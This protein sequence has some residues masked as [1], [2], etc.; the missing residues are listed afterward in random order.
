MVKSLLFAPRPAAL[1][2]RQRLGKINWG[3]VMVLA[4][5]AAIGV[6]M[7]YSVAGGV[8]EPWA[9]RHALRFLGG[10]M[11]LT[12][13]AVVDLRWWMALA[14]PAYVLSLL[15][16]VFVEVAGASGMG[17]QRWLDLGAFRIQPSELMKVALI[18]A[19]ARYFHSLPPESYRK[20]LPLLVPVL[21][22]AIPAAL[23]VRQPDLGTAA[24]LVMGGLGIIFLAGAR[25]WIFWSG[26]AASLAAIPFVWERLR[27]YQQERILTFLNPERDPLGAG[28]QILQ[29]KIALGSGGVF[30][31]GFLA[32]TQSHLNFLPEMKTDFIFTV[33]AEEFGLI[34]GL[35]LLSLYAILILYGLYVSLSSRSHFARLLAGG[36]TL[37]IFLYVFINVGMVMGLLPV[38]GVPLP[39]VSYGGSAMMTVM[40]AFGLL[41]ACA[42]N[43]NLTLPRKD[44]FG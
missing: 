24:L 17:G 16:L 7:L 26:A 3:V 44:P 35:A 5:I 1:G 22:V 11:L 21:L 42:I 28:Y 4:A 38:V 43:R 31:K 39:L 30:G 32:G 19:L 41:M 33:L 14:Y 37:T 29:S 15:L 6:V 23:V 27:D 13:V 8:W 36:L 40:V 12:L 9:A 2:P 34:G 25:A 10:I 18:L 20:I